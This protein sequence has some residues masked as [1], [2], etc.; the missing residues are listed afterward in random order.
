MAP[1]KLAFLGTPDFAVPTLARLIEAGHEIAAVYTRPARPRDRGQKVAATPVQDF[2]E[3]HGLPVRTPPS[4]KGEEEIRAFQALRLDAAIVAAYGLLLPKPVLETPAFGCLNLHPS[5]LPR[6]RGAAPIPRALLAGDQT[7]G[8]TIMLVN[9]GLD[10]GPVLLQEKVPIQN[11]DTAGSLEVKLATLGA[12]LMEKA[13]EDLAGGRITPRPQVEKDANYAEKLAPAEGKMD[14]R[15]PAAELERR[16]RAFNPRPGAWFERDGTRIRVW[17]VEIVALAPAKP[18]GTVLDDCLTI[19]TGD[20]AIRLV[21]LQRAGRAVLATDAF[22][23]GHAIPEG[24]RLP[25]QE[26]S[27]EA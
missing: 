12:E 15:L 8:A 5:L 20:G 26:G 19:A 25:S 27:T 21:E 16:V 6:W 23:R 1:L 2:A 14:W 13:L 17:K 18:P 3:R 24:T 22:L 9:E 7:T 4:L 11:D 10:S